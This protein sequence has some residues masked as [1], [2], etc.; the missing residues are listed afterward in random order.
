MRHAAWVA[1]VQVRVLAARSADS[2]VDL[3]QGKLPD[4]SLVVGSDNCQPEGLLQLT[5]IEPG[6]FK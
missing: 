5:F 2:D 1:V 6:Y 4:G 3:W